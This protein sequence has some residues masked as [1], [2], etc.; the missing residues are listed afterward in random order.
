M[1]PE[2]LSPAAEMLIKKLFKTSEKS[3]KDLWIPDIT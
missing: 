2:K 1:M 3:G